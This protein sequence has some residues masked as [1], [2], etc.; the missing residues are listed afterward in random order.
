MIRMLMIAF[1][2]ALG[3]V[4]AQA[5]QVAPQLLTV[6]LTDGTLKEFFKDVEAQ[7]RY[8]FSYKSADVN[9]NAK[10]NVHLTDKPISD[11]LSVA[12]AGKGLEYQM[13]SERTIVIRPKSSNTTKGVKLTVSGVVKES[14]GEPA[15]GATVMVEGTTLG[16]TTDIDGRYTLTNVPDNANIRFSMI[17]SVAQVIKADNTTALA[18]VILQENSSMLDEIVVVGYGTQKRVNLTGAVA[19]ISSD[20]INNR[21]VSNAAAALQGA[22]PSMNLTFT[23]GT[24]DA[25]Y[26]IDIRGTASI[27]GGTPL[28]LCDGMEVELKQITPHDI[29]SV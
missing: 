18:N 2:V 20:D 21:P 7:S 27:N 22:D 17:G 1:V 8:R 10:V 3:A 4:H 23:S 24:L 12:L 16:T 28:I 6:N 25:D 19:T 15:I 9:E 14:N 26:T 13:V 5:Q 29:A 11:V